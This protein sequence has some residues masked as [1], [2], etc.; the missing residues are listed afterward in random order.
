RWGFRQLIDNR[1]ADVVQPD[2]N[3]CGGLTELLKI[4]SYASAHG[5]LMIPHGS[6]VYSY[7]F[8]ATRHES[9]FAEFLMMA[10]DAA[11]I[12][13]MFTPLLTGEPV[14]ERGRIP[15]SALDA[16][17]FG[18]ELDRSLPLERPFPR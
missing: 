3:F 17:G 2:V 5:V 13:P 16:P 14:P 12:V 1:C 4:A 10:P 11:S 9:P 8:V 6:S 7:H 15:V 18:V